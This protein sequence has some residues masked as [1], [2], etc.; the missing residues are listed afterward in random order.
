MLKQLE[1]FMFYYLFFTSLKHTTAFLLITNNKSNIQIIPLFKKMICYNFQ[2][3][4]L[5]CLYNIHIP[6]TVI[7]K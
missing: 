3:D 7:P 5:F 6:N 4:Y 1:V 2:N